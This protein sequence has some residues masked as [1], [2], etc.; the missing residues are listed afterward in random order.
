MDCNPPGSFVHG[1]AQARIVGCHF[2]IPGKMVVFELIIL[3]KLCNPMDCS[4][5]G[6]SS[7]WNSPGKNTGVCCH[8]LLQGNLPDPGIEPRSPTL[9]ADSL[10][11]EPPGKPPKRVDL[12][13]NILSTN[14]QKS[15]KQEDDPFRLPLHSY[16]SSKAPIKHLVPGLQFSCVN[17]ASFL[18]PF[19]SSEARGLGHLEGGRDAGRS[20]ALSGKC[21]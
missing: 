15:H 21:L 14:K 20:T 10:P 5:P 3:V 6:S 13:L 9:Q 12:V 1:I 8:A 18:R 7:P 19:G 2:L 11:S 17:I 16:P 4:P